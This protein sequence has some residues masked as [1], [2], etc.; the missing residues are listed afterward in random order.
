MSNFTVSDV[1]R[2]LLYRAIIARRNGRD[3]TADA[4]LKQAFGYFY[5]AEEL[6]SCERRA[7]GW[8]DSIADD[9]LHGVIAWQGLSIA[10]GSEWFAHRVAPH[11]HNQF[12][13]PTERPSLYEYSLDL[14]ARRFME[15]VQR[16]LITGQWPVDIDTASMSGYGRLLAALADPGAVEQ[17]LVDFCDWRARTPWVIRKWAPRSAGGSPRAGRSWTP[18]LGSRSFRSSC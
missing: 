3:V 17:A 6:D 4:L 18:R 9:L 10:C 16:A 11:L 15:F 13:H 12:A 2:V 14:P 7:A 8:A 5:W 1:S